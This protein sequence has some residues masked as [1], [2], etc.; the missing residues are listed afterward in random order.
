GRHHPRRAVRGDRRGLR[1][2]TGHHRRHQGR[3]C[4][5]GTGDRAIGPRRRLRTHRRVAELDDQGQRRPRDHRGVRAGHR[6]RRADRRRC[7][8]LPPA[9]QRTARGVQQ[10]AREDHRRRAVLPRSRRAVRL[11]RREPAA[12]RPDHRAALRGRARLTP[13][14][15]TENFEALQR[16]QPYLLDGMLITVQLTVGGA[17]LAFVIAIGLGLLARF[18]NVLLRGFARTVIEVFRGTSL[19][20]QLYFLFFVLPLP[21]F[22]V[23]LPPVVVGIVGLGLNYG[24]YGAEVVRGSVNS[25][26]RGQW[27]ATTAL[28]LSRTQRMWRVIF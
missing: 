4:H 5:G 10:G 16:A 17:L 14:D 9:G 12:R 13:H 6:R 27:E 7:D 18:D 8:G 28:S 23:E 21:P 25:V 22:N 3:Q 20:V 1:R 26:P 15:V 11:H 2:G 24:A 19:L